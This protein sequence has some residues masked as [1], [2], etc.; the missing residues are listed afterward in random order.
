MATMVGIRAQGQKR[1]PLLSP[2]R[3]FISSKTGRGRG[4]QKDQG[5]LRG[6]TRVLDPSLPREENT[7]N[8]TRREYRK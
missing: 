6:D 5:G 1:Q 3:P 4:Q 7:E 2:P 8:T